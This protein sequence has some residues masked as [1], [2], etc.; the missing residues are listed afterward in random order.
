MLMKIEHWSVS[1]A[2]MRE[3]RHDTLA[4]TVL[5]STHYRHYIAQSYTDS[6]VP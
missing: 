2:D 4:V 5:C 6:L 1:T 3:G